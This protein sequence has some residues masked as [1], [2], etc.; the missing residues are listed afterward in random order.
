MSKQ[1]ATDSYQSCQ[2]RVYAMTERGALTFEV[3]RQKCPRF[4]VWQVRRAVKD[5]LSKGHLVS[6]GHRPKLYS[7]TD[8]KPVVRESLPL[9]VLHFKPLKR[10]PFELWR[11]CERAPF[12]PSRDLVALIR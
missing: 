12:D 2:Q 4:T 10:D 6:D 11:R 1:Y 7:R 3:L 5:L 8:V 9:P